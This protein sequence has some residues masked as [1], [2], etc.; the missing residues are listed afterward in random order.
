MTRNKIANIVAHYNCLFFTPGKDMIQDFSRKPE[1]SL[2][3]FDVSAIKKCVELHAKRKCS[4]CSRPGAVSTCANAKCK[5][6]GWY[7]FPCGLRNG[8]VQKQFRTFCYKCGSPGKKK[9]ESQI[10]VVKTEESDWT[11]SISQNDEEMETVDR[12]DNNIDTLLN[13]LDC[14]DFL[15]DPKPEPPA[16]SSQEYLIYTDIA[17]EEEEEEE[18]EE[19]HRARQTASEDDRPVDISMSE[20][21]E[22]QN[23][24]AM[25]IVKQEILEGNDDKTEPCDSSASEQQSVMRSLEEQHRMD[26]ENIENRHKREL[27]L[28]VE[29]RKIEIN[30]KE[31]YLKEVERLQAENEQLKTEKKKKIE[32]NMK[33]RKKMEVDKKNFEKKIDGLKRKIDDGDREKEILRKKCESLE[34]EHQK[35][36]HSLDHILNWAK[37]TDAQRSSDNSHLSCVDEAGMGPPSKKVKHI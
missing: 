17:E 25:T 34:N 30:E 5:K 11:I 18:E 26:K 28:E 14:L 6:T 21:K 8:S 4:F 37:R 19:G 33:L 35:D 23:F 32:D 10:N 16:P 36:K 12:F 2:E 7:H 20:E 22:P 29:K 15:E 1:N 13:P 27:E 31:I 3:G 9:T 24:E